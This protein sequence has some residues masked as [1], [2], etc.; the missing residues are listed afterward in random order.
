[1][2]NS[3]DQVIKYFL[4]VFF[5]LF[6]GSC[7]NETESFSRV[8]PTGTLSMETNL[9]I[10][11]IEQPFENQFGR[12]IAVR[13]DEENNIYVADR[14]NLTIKVFDEDGNY[15]RSLGGRGR[16]PGEFLEMELVEWTPEGNLVIM[17]R[18]I[19]QYTVIS[20]EGEFVEAYPYNMSEQFYPTAIDYTDDGMLALFFDDSPWSE[21]ERENRDLF[22]VYSDDFQELRYS[23]FPYNKLSMPGGYLLAEMMY[24]PGSFTLAKDNSRFYYSPTI[25][26]G[27]LYE[28][29]KNEE[30]LWEYSSTLQGAIPDVEPYVIL[31]SEEEYQEVRMLPGSALIYAAGGPYVGRILSINMGIFFRDDGSLI[32]FY[33][34]RRENEEFTE[35]SGYHYL[36][37]YAQVFD[38]DGSI[39]HYDLL[40]TI[41]ERRFSRTKLFINWQDESGN[42]YMI[43]HVEDVPVIRR[44][45]IEI[46]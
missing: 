15:L 10:G 30:G 25:Y 38:R 20:P 43:E 17:D 7:Q 22:H 39:L 40:T 45:T 12:P 11:Q 33:G 34:I 44:F 27:S 37:M 1:M 21:I 8:E 18:G 19:L 13:T 3:T 9:M 4:A 46:N 42:Y 23:L 41:H 31:D 5:P 24:A 2:M 35:E 26:T 14:A 36:D 29:V 28:F 6:L 32:H 16:G